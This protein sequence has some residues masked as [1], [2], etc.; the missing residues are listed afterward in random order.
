VLHELYDDILKPMFQWLGNK[1]NIKSIVDSLKSVASE[2]GDIIKGFGNLHD[3][4]KDITSGNADKA[5]SRFWDSSKS[6][7][8]NITDLTGTQKDDI[9]G[10]AMA[11]AGRYKL[12]DAS[13]AEF[14]ALIQQESNFNPAAIGPVTKHGQAF[15]LG[16]IMPQ[17]WPKGK[18]WGN[19]QDQLDVAASMFLGSLQAHHGDVKEALH[20]YYGHGEPIPG[21]PTFDQYYE[22]WLQK[23]NDWQKHSGAA[24]QPS[25][26]HSSVDYGGITVNVASTNASAAEIAH[27]VRTSLDERDNA[28]RQR[29]MAQ[30]TG[31]YA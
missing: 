16:Q 18:D 27:A 19:V 1:D 7:S 2:I 13:I 4:Y 10:K 12:G 22:Q 25:A 31:V 29:N 8:Q 3:I 17:N 20:D 5:W 28:R 11:T 9:I 24:I 6:F 30:I 14:L 21:Q 15:G 23:Y 26:M